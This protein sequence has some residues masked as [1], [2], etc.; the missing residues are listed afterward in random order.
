MVRMS[1]LAL[2]N[3][4]D[5]SAEGPVSVV[6]VGTMNGARVLW[7]IT[8][9]DVVAGGAV[10]SDARGKLRVFADLSAAL[11]K[12]RR[13]LDPLNG[14]LSVS[15][16]YV[17][18]RAPALPSDVG[19]AANKRGAVLS[20]LMSTAQLASSS[21]QQMLDGMTGWGEL[22]GTYTARLSEVTA[23]RDAVAL[24]IAEISRHLNELPKVS[25]KPDS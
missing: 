6:A 22:G 10:I 17:N 1:I 11:H 13:A 5:G 19:V 16:Q 23:R 3:I 20:K 25:F 21:Y 9:P 7:S 2:G 12:I 24:D 4:G 15:V 8:L 18:E 14:L